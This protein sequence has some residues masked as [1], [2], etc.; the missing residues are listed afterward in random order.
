MRQVWG[1]DRSSGDHIEAEANNEE[2]NDMFSMF[3][4]EYIK[5]SGSY[6]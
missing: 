4:L 1:T 5:G 6:G 3:S 2:T